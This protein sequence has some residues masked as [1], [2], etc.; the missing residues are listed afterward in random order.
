MAAVLCHPALERHPR[1]SFLLNALFAH[2]YG[3]EEVLACLDDS[4]NTDVRRLARLVYATAPTVE[5]LEVRRRWCVRVDARWRDNRPVRVRLCLCC[6]SPCVYVVCVRVRFPQAS[7]VFCQ[8]LEAK[9]VAGLLDINVRLRALANRVLAG[10]IT[11][12]DVRW[13]CCACTSWPCELSPSVTPVLETVRR[14]VSLV[15]L[16][17]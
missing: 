14:S 13:C 12:N 17:W 2:D 16:V 10:E 9:R 15:S 7:F 11:L 8:E 1:V 5:L 4:E 6:V 3:Y